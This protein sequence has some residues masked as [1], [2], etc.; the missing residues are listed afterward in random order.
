MNPYLVGQN[1]LAQ[2]GLGHLI[3]GF[4]DQADVK[5]FTGIIE[6]AKLSDQ[7]S[8]DVALVQKGHKN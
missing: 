8:R 6:T 2:C 7:L 1:R 5:L 4:G 3:A